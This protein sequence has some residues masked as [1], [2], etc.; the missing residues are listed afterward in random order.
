[1]K[2]G[3]RLLGNGKTNRPC[4]RPHPVHLAE[5]SFID[6]AQSINPP[7]IAIEA[8]ATASTLFVAFCIKHRPRGTARDDLLE[9]RPSLVSGTGLF[10]RQDIGAG[11]ILGQY[12]GRPRSS[13]DMLEKVERLGAIGVSASYA[14]STGRGGE[15]GL[16]LDPTDAQGALSAYPNPGAPWPFKININLAYINEPPPGGDCNCSL[17]DGQDDDPADLCFIASKLISKDSECF[18]DYGPTYNRSGYR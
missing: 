18:V 15:D 7:L 11:T 17:V 8:A 10:A 9:A 5:A 1:M 13:R 3:S 16:Y 12:P 2:A 6:I 4:N 14:A